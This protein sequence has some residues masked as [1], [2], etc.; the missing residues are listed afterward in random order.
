MISL[1]LYNIWKSSFLSIVR[2]LNITPLEELDLL[3]KYLGSESAKQACSIRTS[4]A[5]N[6][7]RGLLRIWQRLDERFGSPEMVEAAL[8][9]KLSDFPR[10]FTKDNKKLYELADI[11]SE[12]EAAKEDQQYA[13]ILL[14]IGRHTFGSPST[15]QVIQRIGPP[16]TTICPKVTSW[17]GHH[18]RSL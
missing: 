12:I 14:L 3:V 11:L 1:K 16:N 15:W 18:S 8:K 17:M 7:S 4:N 10:L 2:E 9:K 6:P 13:E 5:K